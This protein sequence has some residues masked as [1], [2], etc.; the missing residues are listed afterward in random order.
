[1]RL[2][3]LAVR[4]SLDDAS[5]GR[6]VPLLVKIAPDLEDAEVDA[7]ADLALDLGLDGIVATNTTVRRD[8]L[9]SP[10][11]VVSA[12]GAGGLSGPPLQKRSLQV[13]H[14]LRERTGGRLLLVSA[15]GI[16]S[17]D[18]VWERIQAGASLVQAYTGF[19]YGG[20]LWPSRVQRGLAERLRRAGHATLAD[21]VGTTPRDHATWT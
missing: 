4:A 12:A 11:D 10:P 17:A 6:R 9:T 19:V 1:M 8:A 21:A 5:P 18:D 7:V 16:E 2:L 3:L 20:P 14:R 13:L 15:G